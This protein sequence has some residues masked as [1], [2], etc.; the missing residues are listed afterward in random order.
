LDEK[1]KLIQSLK[2]KLKMSTIED[3][4]IAELVALEQEKE[5]LHQEALD[6]KARVLRLEREKVKWSQEKTEY[7]NKVVVAAPAAGVGSNTEELVQAMSQVSLK[8]GEIKGLKGSRDK[9]KQEMQA[10]DERIAQFQKE[11]G[12]LQ[13]RREKLKMR[14]MLGMCYILCASSSV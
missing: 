9:L 1:D 10:K 13:E 14:L 3:P 5:T 11:N 12:V 8:E 6:Y 2:K 7:L 4:Q